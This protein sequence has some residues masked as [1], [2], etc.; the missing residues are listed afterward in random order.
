MPKFDAVLT[1]GIR[2]YEL[3]YLALPVPDPRYLQKGDTGKGPRFNNWNNFRFPDTTKDYKDCV[4][5]ECKELAHRKMNYP[6]FMTWN[7]AVTCNTGLFILDVDSKPPQ[8]NI[9]FYIDPATNQMPLGDALLQYVGRYIDITS[10]PLSRTKSGGYHL[11][12]RAG[13]IDWKVYKQGEKLT[14]PDGKL[15]CLDARN[16]LKG[17]CMEAPTDGYEWVRPLCPLDAL[18]DVPTALLDWLDKVPLEDQ[19]PARTNPR[20]SDRAIDSRP[21]KVEDLTEDEF[22]LLLNYTLN[23]IEA[24]PK[25]RR[26]MHERDK[27]LWRVVRLCYWAAGLGE[28]WTRTIAYSWSRLCGFGPASAIERKIS[29]AKKWSPYAYFRGFLRRECGIQK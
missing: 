9:G 8:D 10:C 19:K 14:G 24:D 2:L 11:Y 7:L 20:A 29:D 21:C 1:E 6:Y 22:N 4:I 23:Y 26:V 15:L 13:D 17:C 28:E 16:P 18:P 27:N 12:F 3:G 5:G 25:C